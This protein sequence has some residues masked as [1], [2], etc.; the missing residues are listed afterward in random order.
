MQRELEAYKVLSLDRPRFSRSGAKGF[1]WFAEQNI[2]PLFLPERIG[3]ER[4]YIPIVQIKLDDSEWKQLEIILDTEIAEK[5]RNVIEHALEHLVA[6]YSLKGRAPSLKELKNRLQDIRDTS[7]R[8]LN[9][10]G[11]HPVDIAG[12]QKKKQKTISRGT[13]RHVLSTSQI[14]NRYLLRA[15]STKSR[16]LEKYLFPVRTIV[17]ICDRG[18]RPLKKRASKSGSK[19]DAGLKYVVRVLVFVAWK[20][21][22][23]T[24]H[25]LPSPKTKKYEMARFPLL[26][27]VRKAISIGAEKGVEALKNSDAVVPIEKEVA[28]KLLRSA[29]DPTQHETIL[30]VV[31][32]AQETAKTMRTHSF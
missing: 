8:L 14:I 9:L 23:R 2:D 18:L 15:A 26:A 5:F 19:Q 29:S 21:T 6:V 12:K 20:T 7:Q 11:A 3:L 32:A 16:S 31:C 4:F 1:L 30:D 13:G 17:E 27:F 10:C 25:E 24:D 22:G 28:I